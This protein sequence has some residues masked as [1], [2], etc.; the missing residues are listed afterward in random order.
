MPKT[1]YLYIN[2]F[3][4]DGIMDVSTSPSQG[5]D[6]RYA[7]HAQVD[8]GPVVKVQHHVNSLFVLP[9]TLEGGK[10]EIIIHGY[11]V[12]YLK[13]DQRF[14]VDYASWVKP[15]KTELGNSRRIIG[16]RSLIGPHNWEDD[17]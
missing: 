15:V 14:S 7:L 17:G 16:R 8:D 9:N 10:T 2:M 12:T 6:E 11:I 4:P 3:N 5:R 13:N 1:D